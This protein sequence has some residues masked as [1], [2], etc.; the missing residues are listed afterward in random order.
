MDSMKWK[1]VEH[2]AIC[3]TQCRYDGSKNVSTS[4][5]VLSSKGGT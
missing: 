2:M 5:L 1:C 3:E 4:D